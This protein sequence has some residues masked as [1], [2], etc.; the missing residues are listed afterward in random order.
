MIF[1][2]FG[3]AADL[4]VGQLLCPRLLKGIIVKFQK[5]RSYRKPAPILYYPDADTVVCR[6][7]ATTVTGID[8]RSIECGFDRR[9][10]CVVS[11]TPTLLA[12]EGL[13]ASLVALKVS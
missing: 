11:A 8:S 3:E 13:P 12:N 1:Q 10:G 6:P 2:S 7:R 4:V 9:G 5:L